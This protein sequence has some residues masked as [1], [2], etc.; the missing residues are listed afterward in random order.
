[1]NTQTA[2]DLHLLLQNGEL[3]SVELVTAVF[4]QIDVKE[5]DV[6][7]YLALYRSKALEAAEN[8][9]AKIQRGEP[10][11]PLEGIPIAIKDNMCIQ[12][13]KM[14]CGSKILENYVAPY[15]ATVITKLKQAGAIFIGKTNMDEF[16]MGSSTENSA[17]QITC[18]PHDLTTVPGGSSGGS[19][20]AVAAHETILALGSDTGGSIRQPA[21]FCGIVGMKPTYGRVS[22]YGLVAFASSLD[23]IGPMTKD[24][25]DTA[26]LL[27]VICGADPKDST[28][29]DLPV[30]DFTQALTP[31][32]KG[33]KIGVPKE[34]MGPGISDEV[35]ARVVQT[36]DKLKA[37]GASWEEIS[38]SSFEAAVATYYI[39]APA[40]ASANLARYDGVKYGLRLPEKTLR[41]MV[42]Q[43][44]NAGFGMEVKRRILIGSY[45]L[46]AG[47]YDAYYLKAQKLRTLILN[48]FQK[49][50]EKYDVIMSPTTPTTAFKIGEKTNDPLQMYLSDIATIPVN[51][52]GLPG[53]SIPCG[54]DSHH[55]PVG[56]QIIGKPF[57]EMTV[58]RAAYMVEGQMRS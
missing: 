39:L 23:Q 49:A 30:P 11:Q 55:L 40:E 45:V 54:T 13:Q 58:L 38:L 15:D 35:K 44:R 51:L 25:T 33:F 28:S 17:F 6:R 53:I 56:L 47:Y 3:K 29:V 34:L 1:M 9:D 12:G 2:N 50:F 27:N 46:S 36:L 32:V 14:T 16:A 5:S 18:N 8:V 19:A 48:D 57:D 21:A 4:D 41:S 37:A 22:R 10:L 52:A 31:D 24:V 26:L 20:A 7:A 42:T 43:T